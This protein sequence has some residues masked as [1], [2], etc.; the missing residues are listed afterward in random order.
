MHFMNTLYS[1]HAC[2]AN[3]HALIHLPQCVAQWGP[4][5]GFSMFGHE[6]YHSNLKRKIHGTRNVLP[7][8]C[9]FMKLDYFIIIIIIIIFLNALYR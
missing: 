1:Q 7:Q 9:R 3:M 6:S 5:W 4:L 8:I 2:S